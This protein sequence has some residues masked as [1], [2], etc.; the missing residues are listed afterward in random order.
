VDRCDECRYRYDDV[1][2]TEL[3]ALLIARA[4]GYGA[5]L[6]QGSG[7]ALRAHP[8]PGTWSALEYACHVR[9][10]VEVQRER[11]ARTE[12]EDCPEFLPMG[13]EERVVTEQYNRQGPTTV[14]DELQRAARSLAERLRQLDDETWRRA[15]V[16]PWPTRS[17]RTIAWMARHTAH[18][19]IHHRRDLDWVLAAPHPPPGG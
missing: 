12:R 2:L 1:A 7:G 9:D 19:V 17:H 15:C 6:R 3:P 13:R 11:I 4:D 16:Y 5:P 8:R 10:V 18:E 14:A